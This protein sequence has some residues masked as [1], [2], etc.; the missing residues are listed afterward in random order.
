MN[1]RTVYVL[2]EIITLSTHTFYVLTEITTLSTHTFCVLTEITTLG[3]RT[4]Y[5]LT[6]V[7]ET[8]FGQSGIGQ[9]SLLCILG[10]ALG[11]GAA[12][13]VVQVDERA[14]LAETHGCGP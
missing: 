2:T 8:L 3:T 4:V 7:I 10:D 5:V 6:E 9:V 13:T 14:F 11:G 12:Q 1:T